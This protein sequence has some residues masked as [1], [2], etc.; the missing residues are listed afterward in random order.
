M[1]A[2]LEPLGW[3]RTTPA[4]WP[5]DHERPALD[6]V[7]CIRRIRRT[8][9]LLA[10]GVLAACGATAHGLDKVRG[11]DFSGPPT[12]FAFQLEDAFVLPSGGVLLTGRDRST[13][14]GDVWVVELRSGSAVRASRTTVTGASNRIAVPW[15]AWRRP[16]VPERA[17]VVPA[18]AARGEPSA[19]EVAACSFG[20]AMAQRA[21]KLRVLQAWENLAPGTPVLT[22]MTDRIRPTGLPETADPQIVLTFV[23]ANVLG[24]LPGDDSHVEV[25][26]LGEERSVNPLAALQLPYYVAVDAFSGIT[27]AFRPKPRADVAA[28]DERARAFGREQGCSCVVASGQANAPSCYEPRW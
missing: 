3:L 25:A 27:L 4:T 24:P 15:K 26:F 20:G 6:R 28:P 1:A 22:P 13:D 17:T 5:V 9:G 23:A 12:R 8:F 2:A 10:A 14:S 18:D 11:H 7:R 21:R 16:T 19:E